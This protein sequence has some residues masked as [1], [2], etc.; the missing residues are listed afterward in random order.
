MHISLFSLKRPIFPLLAFLLINILPG[1]TFAEDNKFPAELQQWIPWVLYEQEEKTCTLETTEGSKRYCTWP[2]TLEL[3]VRSDGADFSQQWLIETRSLVPLPGNSPFWPVQ[4]QANGKNIPVSKH[5][6]RP[7]V[8]LD[9]GKQKITGIF[10]WKTLPENI[11]VPAETGLVRLTLLGKK[12]NNLQLDP[13]GRLWF[14]Q[15]RK[16]QKNDE[17]SLNIQV[18]RKIEDSVPLSQ[19]IRI[20]L[21]VSGSPRQI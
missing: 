2:S 19:H 14:Q 9:P 18:F 15:K 6:G 11:L 12:V 20:L 7:A 3:D 8:W 21:T 10:S 5:K 1:L 13:K 16:D 17:E 4:V